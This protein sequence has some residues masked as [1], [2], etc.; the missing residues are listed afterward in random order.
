MSESYLYIIMR[1]DLASLNPGKA[2]AQAA[3]AANQFIYEWYL[4][5]LD[6]KPIEPQLKQIRDWMGDRGF[7]T[8]ITLDGGENW[9]D[10]DN[11]MNLSARHGL[12]SSYVTDPGYPVQDGAITHLITLVT[13][14]YVFVPGLALDMFKTLQPLKKMPLHP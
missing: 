9:T 10:I 6:K 7:G 1:S 8:T 5:R 11:I 2:M 12:M 13:C 3:H 14:A 4:K